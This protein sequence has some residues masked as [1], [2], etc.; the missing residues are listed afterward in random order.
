M[1]GMDGRK[2]GWEVERLGGV[3]VRAWLR[4]GCVGVGVGVYVG[5][6]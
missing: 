6:V 2:D 3:C 5:R 1:E 4:Y